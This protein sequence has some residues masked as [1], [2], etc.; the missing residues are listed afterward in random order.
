MRLS[1]ETK[2]EGESTAEWVPERFLEGFQGVIHGGIVSTA[3]DE[4]MSKAVSASGLRAYTAE[5]RIRLRHM[6][7]P[8]SRVQIRGWI[9]GRTKRL[10]RTEA[11][12]TDSDGLELAHGWG[13]F[14]VVS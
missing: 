8:E 6:V 9:N 4:A 3:L 1:F 10:I 12:I 13:S 11:A 2:P 5:L 7:I 14:L